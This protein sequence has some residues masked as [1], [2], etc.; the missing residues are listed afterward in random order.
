[1]KRLLNVKS[2][3]LLVK[4]LYIRYERLLMPATLVVGFLVDYLTFISIKI[5]LTFTVLSI[6]W[7]LAGTTIFFINYYDSEKINFSGK[8]NLSTNLKYFRLFAPLLIQ[9]LFG[10][11][12]GASLIFYWFSGALSV[13]WPIILIIALLMVFNDIF[14]RYFLRPALQI[15]VYFFTTISLV[16]LI[17]P[18]IFKS[19]DPILFVVGGFISLVVFYFFIRFLPLKK[20]NEKIQKNKFFIW[21]FGTFI[22]MNVFYFLNII[23]PIPLALREAGLYHSLEISEGKYKMRGEIE[24]F[25]E[26]I[27]PGQTLHVTGS[28]KVYFYTAIFAPTELKTEIVHHWQYYDKTKNEWVDKGF[29][30]FEIVGGRKEGYKG[31]SFMSDLA[32]G[33]WR[34]Y[35]QNQRGQVLGRIKFDVKGVEKKVELKEVIR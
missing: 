13:S 35:V 15:A 23:P 27:I 21:V 4:N 19:L 31:Y 26:E 16:T 32:E 22:L 29:L 11:L 17:A 5:S 12:L 6:Y 30:P 14:R 2:H 9:Y 18:F 8:L 20:E 1:M 7:L 10:A 34:I 3:Y 24:G 28:E 25:W 33:D